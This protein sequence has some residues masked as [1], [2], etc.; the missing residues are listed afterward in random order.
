MPESQEHPNLPPNPDSQI[1]PFETESPEIK[2]NYLND[3][4][5]HLIRD[6]VPV[7]SGQEALIYRMSGSELDDRTKTLLAETGMDFDKDS[8]VKVLKVFSPG[9]AKYEYEYQKKAY[10]IVEA[11]RKKGRTDL[12]WVP[13]PTDLRTLHISAETKDVLNKMGA[14]L[15]NNQV[16]IFSMDFVEGEDLQEIFYRWILKHVP[17]EK[18]FLVTADPDTA[19]FEQLHRDVSSI[20]EFGHLG[21]QGT[22]ETDNEL[23]A[24]RNKVLTFLKRTGYK[25]GGDVIEKI[26]NTRELLRENK[27]F[28]NDE[29]ERNFM[30]QGKELFLIDFARATSRR[31]EGESYYEL[32]RDL[33]KLVPEIEQKEE[34][35][36]NAAAIQRVT[37]KSQDRFLRERFK[38]L[39]EES[40]NIALNSML[41]VRAEAATT[42]ESG[43]ED[44][45]GLMLGLVR[46]NKLTES[47]AASILAHMKDSM[48][49]PVIKWGKVKGFHIRNQAIYNQ[50]DNYKPLF[51]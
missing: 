31:I 50:I 11:E 6:N 47:Q 41:L 45:I 26:R 34:L 42:T 10:Q 9:K 22:A 30:L 37:E 36:K 51:Q 12:A 14:K 28:H 7:D 20:L 32:E 3:Q 13:K 21:P 29:H 19:S 48:K 15:S 8:A 39:F 2:E 35:E 33:E 18:S 25:I 27:V 24:R 5:E 43:M 16:E 44:F 46:E 17:P 38:P 1:E 40:K 49:K 23:K 4:Y